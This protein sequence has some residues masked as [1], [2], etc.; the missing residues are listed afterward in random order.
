MK[1]AKGLE[2]IIQPLTQSIVHESNDDDHNEQRTIRTTQ[3]KQKTKKNLDGIRPRIKNTET[4]RRLI[5]NDSKMKR[6]TKT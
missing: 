3:P 2:E 5:L 1:P 6:Y 4:A